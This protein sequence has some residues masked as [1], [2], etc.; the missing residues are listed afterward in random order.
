MEKADWEKLVATLQ[1]QG[2]IK[3]P[4][5][6]KSLLAIPRVRFVPVEMRKYAATDTPLQIGF[7]QTVSAPH[8]VAIMN[9][10]LDLQ[11]GHKVLEVGA[12]S[13]WHAATIAEIVSPIEAPRSEWGHV[14]TVEIM[15]T[16]AETAK[17]NIMITGYGDRVSIITGDGS[18][19]YVEKAPMTALWSL[20]PLL[21]CLKP[22]FDQLKVWWCSANTSW[23]RYL[24]SALAQNH[25]ASRR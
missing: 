14:Y 11:V 3:T 17:R 20:Q 2:T 9:E 5:V 8:M 13:G 24:I 10:A 4:E 7:A 16:L 25:Q 23:Q 15:S 22:L 21:K 6:A 12:G 1:K 19:G 18:K